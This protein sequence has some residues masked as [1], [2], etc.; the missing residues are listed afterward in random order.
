MDEP[1]NHLDIDSKEVLE[2]ALN[3]YEGTLFFISHDRYFIN[4]L[5]DRI[6]EFTPGGIRQFLG[7]YDDYQDTL[8]K[9]KEEREKKLEEE[10]VPLNR[11]QQKLQYKKEKEK[12]TDLKKLKKSIVDAEKDIETMEERLVEIDQA[13]CQEEVYSDPAVSLKYTTEKTQVEAK[14]DQA[15]E[16][17]ENLTSQLEETE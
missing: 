2:G 1:T 16:T 15:M 3:A 6:I 10:K 9:E 8:Q 11:T 12:A 14:I 13:L 5:A 17:W 4:A 7:N